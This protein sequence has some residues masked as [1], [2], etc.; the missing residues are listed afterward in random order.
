MV[1]RGT[2][3]GDL[4]GAANHGVSAGRDLVGLGVQGVEGRL[5]FDGFGVG[6]QGEVQA[7]FLHHD[8]EA[9]GLLLQGEHGLVRAHE[10]QAAGLHIALAAA[11]HEGTGRDRHLLVHDQAVLKD[12]HG[13]FGHQARGGV[14]EQ[15]L[16]QKGGRGQ[17]DERLPKIEHAFLRNMNER[18]NGVL[19]LALRPYDRGISTPGHAFT[20]RKKCNVFNV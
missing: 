5:E 12:L 3:L 2:L 14:G 10:L 11:G 17:D 7:A 19:C 6:L 16:G 9:L 18:E 4:D 1:S 8:H 15:G 20:S 13:P